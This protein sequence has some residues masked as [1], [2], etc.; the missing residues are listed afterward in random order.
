MG[1]GIGRQL[2]RAEFGAAHDLV[3]GHGMDPPTDAIARFEHEHLEFRVGGRKALGSYEARNAGSD[4]DH[5][6]I[7]AKALGPGLPAAQSVQARARQSQLE[8][9]S[10]CQHWCSVR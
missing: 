6:V 3:P 1:G 10:P 4:H 5:V 8:E 2:Q 7:R 9:S